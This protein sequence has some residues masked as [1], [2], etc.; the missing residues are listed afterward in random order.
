L[1]FN[2]KFN[3][4][5][6]KISKNKISEVEINKLNEHV[7]K[8]KP[9]NISKSG[10]SIVINIKKIKILNENNMYTVFKSNGKYFLLK[11]SILSLTLGIT[12]GL[13]L[14]YTFTWFKNELKTYLKENNNVS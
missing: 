10:D 11:I 6:I 8:F 14:Y 4:S 5:S 13:I 7:M 12:I 2:I 1:C 3:F 9:K